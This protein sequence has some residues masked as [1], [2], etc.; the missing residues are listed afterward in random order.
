VGAAR[1]GWRPL[2]RPSSRLGVRAC[3]HTR[4]RDRLGVGSLP[5]VGL[6]PEVGDDGRPPVS[7]SGRGARPRW[8][9]L[10]RAAA[11]GGAN[12]ALGQKLRERQR[13]SAT[14]AKTKNRPEIG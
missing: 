9:K 4:V 5:P 11:S 13:T 12:G 14:W 1:L 3:G 10:G 7:G 2:N 6:L 8:A